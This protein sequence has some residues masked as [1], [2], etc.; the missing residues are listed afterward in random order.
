MALSFLYLAFT[1]ILQLHRLR[2]QDGDDL[3]VEI[4]VLRHEVAVLR[5][6]VV[7]PVLE[8]LFAEWDRLMGRSRQGW[9]FVQSETLRRWHRDLVRRKWTHAHLRGTR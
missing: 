3:A 7:R 9:F 4:V 2:R 1:K 8:P 6:Q 5:P